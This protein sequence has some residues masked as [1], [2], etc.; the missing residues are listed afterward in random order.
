MWE[1]LKYRSAQWAGI[2]CIGAGIIAGFSGCA[3]DRYQRSTGEYIDDKS[4][5]MRVKHA[6]NDNP[7]YKFKDVVVTSFKGDVQLSGFVNSDQQKDRAVDLAKNVQ[8]VKQVEN[9]ISVK[10]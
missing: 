4:L 1:K 7:D 8:G 5:D 6:L 2:V 3:G 9:N 10:P